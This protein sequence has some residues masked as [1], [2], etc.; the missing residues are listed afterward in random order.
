MEV[1]LQEP[2]ASGSSRNLT[3][4]LLS[5]EL[6]VQE[7]TVFSS[8]SSQNTVAWLQPGYC[9]VSYC[10]VCTVLIIINLLTWTRATAHNSALYDTSQ[11]RA[12]SPGP[13]Q[14]CSFTLPTPT[15]L[16]NMACFCTPTT[17]LALTFSPH[18]LPTSST[19]RRR[20]YT[21]SLTA[22]P[23]P[24]TTLSAIQALA[25]QRG[26]D[27]RNNTT[28][29]L[30]NLRLY[31]ATSSQQI[32]YLTGL[33][34]PTGRLHI[35]SYKSLSRSS[36]SPGGALLAVSPGMLV[37]LAALA[38]AASRG[39]TSVYGLAINDAPDQHRRLVRYL[40]RFGGER[41]MVVDDS[42]RAVPARIV[43]GGFGTVIRADISIMLAR[44]VAMLQRGAT[45]PAP[46]DLTN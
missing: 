13:F 8:F 22:T 20:A 11:V 15:P 27:L 43:Y 36:A 38:E 40:R 19:P 1:H 33:V 32:A 34:L 31:S 24:P 37:F 7:F 44:G 25:A 9:T 39:A 42:L 17:S 4:N 2:A 18:V 14:F 6:T 21:P 29:P 10:T 5:Q 46:S 16:P 28:G 23:P 3:T 30:L 12:Q 26:Y 35:E 41:V 45:L